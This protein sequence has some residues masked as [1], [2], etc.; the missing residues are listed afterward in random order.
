MKAIRE[1]LVNKL[2]TMSAGDAK[3]RIVILL[4]FLS[5]TEV[6]HNVTQIVNESMIEETSVQEQLSLSPE[7]LETLTKKEQFLFRLAQCTSPDWWSINPVEIIHGA[8]SCVF[9]NK[10][11]LGH[12]TFPE[13]D[14]IWGAIKHSEAH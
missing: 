7:E 13:D 3:E 2:P 5:S 4:G 8:L 11:D 14:V 12:L 10:L 1:H 6:H 9:T